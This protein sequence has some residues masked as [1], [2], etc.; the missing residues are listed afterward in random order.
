M[1]FSSCE[2]KPINNGH[3][4]CAPQPK[5]KLGCPKCSQNAKEVLGDTLKHLLKDGV[6][7]KIN[8]YEG[9][10]YCKTSTCEVIYFKE[11]EIL[12]QKDMSVVVGLKDGAK[13][14]NICY[15]FGWSKERIKDDLLQDGKSGALDNI[16]H[17]MATI[18]CS[19]ETKN[20]SGSCC[21]GDVSKVVK[22]IQNEIKI[23][24]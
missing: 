2:T 1:K 17:N 13:P 16:K 7:S 15:C 21:M 19:C 23:L 6:K 9:F 11:D 12:T 5:G 4:C 14:A 3:A 10:H 24:N 8:S 20:P 18:G 22:E